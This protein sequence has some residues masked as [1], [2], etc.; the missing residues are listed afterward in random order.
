MLQQAVT[1]HQVGRWAEAE[2]L[3]RRLLTIS[4][5]HPDVLHLLGVLLAQTNRHEQALPFL[6]QAATLSP[7]TPDFWLSL[8]KALK[9]YGCAFESVDAYQ[10]A[11]ALESCP[12]PIGVASLLAHVLRNLGR[13]QD[14][15]AVYH[16]ALA[17][18]PDN[19]DLLSALAETMRIL[20]QSAEAESLCNRA[21]TL[22]PNDAATHHVL[23]ALHHGEGR[24]VEAEAC[25]RRALAL[26]SQ[27]TAALSDQAA[28]WSNFGAFCAGQG[29]AIEAIDACRRALD[30]QPEMVSAWVTLGNALTDRGEIVAAISAYKSA[31]SFCPHH[32]GALAALTFERRRLCDWSGIEALEQRTLTAIEQDQGD[33]DPFTV[34]ALTSSTALQRRCAVSWTRRHYPSPASAPFFQNFAKTNAPKQ[35]LTLGYLSADFYDHATAWLIAELIELH[36]RNRFCVQGYSYGPDDGGAMRRRLQSGFDVFHDIRTL[37]DR[38]A[39]QKI[40]E[41]GVDILIDLKGHTRDSRLGIMAYRPAPVQMTYLGYPGCLGADF[42]DYAVVDSIVAPQDQSEMFTEKLIR[43]PECYQI[44]D[45]RR[46]RPTEAPPRSAFGLPETG[47]VFCAFNNTWKITPL[48]FSTWMKI[49]RDV[50]DSTLWLLATVPAAS[51]FLRRE[52]FA[53]QIDPQRLVFA[54]RLPLSEHL[55]RHRCADLF[56]DTLPYNAHT[57]ASD[58]LWME[59]PV[60]T[61]MGESFAGRVAASLLYAVGAPELVAQ[62]LDDYQ[63][64]ALYLAQHPQRLK[65]IRQKLC[66]SVTDSPLFDSY[67]F[68]RCFENILWE[69]RPEI[70]QGAGIRLQRHIA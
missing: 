5:H 59:C 41:D 65:E 63:G 48:V 46:P 49:L 13:N 66:Q 19:P 38:Q 35:R 32:G 56:L 31:L 27:T 16:R 68:A 51:D 67:R 62:S 8:A 52:A 3:Y 60:L 11:L 2:A 18:A 34:L 12:N 20:G 58:A 7:Q 61:C 40:A 53:R 23:A 42:I 43:M 69:R 22:R 36:D 50:P 57:T 44:N 39:A 6:R 54:P 10:Q 1:H 24:L 17:T 70:T 47:F 15:A 14:A 64:L 37:S 29:R 30:L 33:I 55:A 45:Q 4:P 21:L 25:Y 26:S 28:L 9:D